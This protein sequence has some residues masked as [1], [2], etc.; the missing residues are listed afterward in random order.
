LRVEDRK[1]VFTVSAAFVVLA[2]VLMLRGRVLPAMAPAG[3]AALLMLMSV[4]L[5]RTIP[6]VHRG[7][8]AGAHAISRVTTPIILGIVYYLVLTPTG[9]IRRAFR[10]V[11]TP[12]VARDPHAQIPRSARDD[13]TFWITREVR[14][15]PPADMRR[16]F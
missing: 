5:P 8:M 13:N 4:L 3:V 14:A 9:L 15:R 10:R 16:Q 2:G 7:W 11:V 1:F 12:G 6:I